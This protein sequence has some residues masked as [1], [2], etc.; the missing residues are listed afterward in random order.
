MT[1][2]RYYLEGGCIAYL[3]TYLV[4]CSEGR[5]YYF[6]AIVA[7]GNGRG[8]FGIGIAFGPTPKEARSNAALSAIQNMDFIDLDVGRT[9]MTP[10][11]GQ[12]YSAHVKSKLMATLRGTHRRHRKGFSHAFTDTYVYPFIHF[13]TCS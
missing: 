2:Y 6:R 7:V 5:V 12:E 9:L 1:G 4:I 13:Y 3:P 10:V 8:L 11:H